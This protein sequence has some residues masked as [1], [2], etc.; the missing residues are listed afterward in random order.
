MPTTT[1]QT[2]LPLYR[3]LNLWDMFHVC[4]LSVL[5]FH[6][7]FLALA[8]KLNVDFKGIADN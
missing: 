4:M 1:S 3:H 5:L 2:L 7:L 6:S 8:V